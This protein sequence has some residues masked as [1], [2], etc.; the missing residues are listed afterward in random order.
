MAEFLATARIPC[1]PLSYENKDL[2]SPKELLV[3]Y[4]TG[5]VWVCKTDG[6]FIDISSSVKETIIEHIKED[7]EFAQN[8]TIEINGDTYE[9]STIIANQATNIQQILDALGY[10]IDPETGKVKFD[11]LEK[12][13]TI[14][15]D[16]GEI[17]F[18]ITTDNITETDNKKFVTAE[19][20]EKISKATHPEILRATIRGG[21]QAWTGSDAPYTQDV[22]VDGILESDTPVVDI[23]LGDIYD[24]I[25]KQLDSYAYIYKILT[26]DGYIRV[27]ASQPT[28]D[29]L[30]VQMKVDR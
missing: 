2:A 8:I 10:Y 23:S 19:E 30:T 22:T 25:Q 11:L 6:T 15:P 4:S 29:D 14:N 12:I 3:D 21:S 1:K 24:T 17:E 7:P 26:F 27:F 18:T 16:T 13:A 20:K 5:N 28:E 9:L